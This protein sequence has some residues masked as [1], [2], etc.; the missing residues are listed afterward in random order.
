MTSGLSKAT[1]ALSSSLANGNKTDVVD[2]DGVGVGG[3]DDDDLSF[4]TVVGGN[5]GACCCCCCCCSSEAS[6]DSAV[7]LTDFV[8]FDFLDDS[9]VL[10]E[11]IV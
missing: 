11:L 8:F 2:D 3:D 10:L 4:S 5:G 9:F 7:F 6:S 1:V